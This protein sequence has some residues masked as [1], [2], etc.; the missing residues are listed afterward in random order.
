MAAGKIAIRY[1]KAVF[2][3]IKGDSKIKTIISELKTFGQMLDSNSEL[4][5]LANSQAFSESDRRGVVEDLA[6]K[7]GLSETTLRV[8]LVL[9]EMKRL[10]SVTEITERLNVL[11]LNASSVVPM[12]VESSNTLEEGDRG[13][14]ENK[15]S[16]ILGKKV[17]ATYHVDPGLLGG[18]K[19]TAGSR[20][21][22]GSLEGWLV[23]LEERLI[24]GS[25]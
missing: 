22:D 3:S 6:K 17:E 23:E 11:S 15:F 18:L 10:S 16:Q 12:R 1:A 13:K 4:Q 20:T 19:V 7:L 24:G 21:F 14:I 2:D 25:H 9:S 8:L 5:A